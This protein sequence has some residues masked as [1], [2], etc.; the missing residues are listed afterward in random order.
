[1]CPNT[2]QLLSQRGLALKRSVLS[3]TNCYILFTT[4]FSLTEFT[5][6]YDMIFWSLR[7]ISEFLISARQTVIYYLQLGSL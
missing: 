3:W 6:W 2:K 5:N 4:W 1:M 7:N